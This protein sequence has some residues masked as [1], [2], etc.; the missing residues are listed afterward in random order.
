MILIV[1]CRDHE[2]KTQRKN[3]HKDTALSFINV[4]LCREMAADSVTLFTPIL[5][6]YGY[7]S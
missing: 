5:A 4:G 3:L 2:N 1:L 6:I 7:E